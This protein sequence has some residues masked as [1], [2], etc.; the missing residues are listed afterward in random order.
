MD[1]TKLF[2][3]LKSAVAVFNRKGVSHF[4]NA[5]PALATGNF[6]K[7]STNDFDTGTIQGAFEF[8]VIVSDTNPAAKSSTDGLY[9]GFNGSP[10][11]EKVPVPLVVQ[12]W[13]FNT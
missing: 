13:E 10:E 1:H 12:I 5:G 4:V 7:L 6:W 2:T 8:T 11:G 9:I 3:V